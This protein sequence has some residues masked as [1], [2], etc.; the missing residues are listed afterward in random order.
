MRAGCS[1][2]ELASS[3]KFN[4]ISFAITETIIV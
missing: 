2:G 3:G 4:N 1:P